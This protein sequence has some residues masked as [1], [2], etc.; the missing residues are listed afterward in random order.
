[1]SSMICCT[2][3]GGQSD[4]L[5][6][7]ALSLGIF[8][9]LCIRRLLALIQTECLLFI[10]SDTLILCHPVRLYNSTGTQEES[11]G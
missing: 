8:N 7:S 6:Q 3:F 5:E 11:G 4:W 10:A 9:P 1:M 2:S